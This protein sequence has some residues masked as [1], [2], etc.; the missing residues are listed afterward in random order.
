MQGM[1]HHTRM[2][3]PAATHN[4]LYA[5]D[6]MGQQQYGHTTGAGAVFDTTPRSSSLDAAAAMNMN[7][8]H[9]FSPRAG[10]DGSGGAYGNQ[11]GQQGYH[12]QQQQP[13][14]F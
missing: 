5:G 13:R 14:H 1:H 12:Q 6:S 7:M 10:G 3:M 9:L 2:S 11:G 4:P 8:N